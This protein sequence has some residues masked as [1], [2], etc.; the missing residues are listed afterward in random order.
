MPEPIGKP[1][2]TICIPLYNGVEYIHE[3]LMSIKQQV[4]SKWRTIIGVNG[5]G[6]D[7][8]EVLKKVQEIIRQI[9]DD[10]FFVVNL[11][12][13]KGIAQADNALIEL[14]QTEWI[15]H[16]DADDLWH[17]QKLEFQVQALNQLE[18]KGQHIDLIGTVC[19]YFGELKHCPKL[20]TGLLKED[21]FKPTNPLIHSSILF[22][23]GALYYPSEE[24]G[25]VPQDYA[26]YLDL[27][28]RGG[29]MYNI[30][31][32]LTFH[33]IY[34]TSHFNASGKQ[35]IK[36]VMDR[37]WSKDKDYQEATVVSAFYK[38][39]SKFKEDVYIHWIRSFFG[40][41]PC[42]L[43]LFTEQEYVELFKDIRKDFLNKTQIIVLSR[44]QWVA[45]TKWTPQLWE[46][47][48]LKDPESKIH[49]PDLYKIWYEK[50][51]FVKKAI[52]INPFGHSKFVW[53]DAGAVRCA[54][55]E[56]WM[57]C[58]ARADR[59]PEDRILLL[60]IDEFKEEDFQ[61]QAD[62]LYGDFLK[63]NRIGGTIQAA[64]ALTWLRWSDLYDEMMQKYI[65]ANRFIGKDQSI[66]ASVIMEN[67]AY[68]MLIR[69]FGYYKHPLNLWFFLGLWLGANNKRFKLLLEGYI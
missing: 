23:K 29:F 62:G 37:F 49:S 66:M 9:G 15:A 28:G 36:L 10:R 43:V 25:V 63:K 31:H 48:M 50:K 40:K 51:E 27:L 45:N 14:T 69:P 35:D 7:G 17:P 33:R 39:P 2:I 41:I 11:P 32:P 59:I 42:S 3:T 20:A 18:E 55:V 52:E 24:G 44:E 56:G 21:D 22:R 58:F 26:A 16:L 46:E 1:D 34:R 12:S 64:S 8:G 67:P 19:Q 5:H 4:Y 38:M 13:V 30:E 47:Q 61:L 57:S 68:V 53:C 65:N 6:Q 60:Q 54:E